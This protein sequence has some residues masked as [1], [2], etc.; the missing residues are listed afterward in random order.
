MVT[1]TSQAAKKPLRMSAKFIIYLLLFFLLTLS[2][3]GISEVLLA[4]DW[5]FLWFILIAGLLSGYFLGILRLSAWRSLLILL[6][7]GLIVPLLF[8]TDL[9]GKILP[10][11][12][13]FYMYSN[14]TQTPLLNFQIDYVSQSEL[15]PQT[16]TS[17]WTVTYRIASWIRGFVI[18]QP[19]IDPV[20]VMVAWCMVIWSVS[21]WAGW[22]ICRSLNSLLAISPLLLLYLGTLSYTR[23]SPVSVSLILG[24][25]LILIAVVQYFK[26]EQHWN[27]SGIPYPERKYRQIMSFA[28]YST[29]GI[30]FFSAFISSLSLQRI[31]SWSIFRREPTYQADTSLAASLGIQPA[32][33]TIP[34]SFSTY[35]D[36]GLPRD[37]LIGSGPELQHIQVMSVEVAE[38]QSIAKIIQ[39][40]SFYW[41]GYTYDTYTGYGWSSST[42]YS[43]TFEAGHIFQ[44]GDS[45]GHILVRQEVRLYPG[46]DRTIYAFGEP[47]TVNVPGIMAW[48]TPQDLFGIQTEGKGAYEITSL[49]P[50]AGESILNAA[51]SIYPDWI[52]N[53]YLALPSDI[54]SRVKELAIHLTATAPTPYDRVRAIEK[55][56]R[57]YEYT[58]EV[59][60]PSISQ[61][62]VDDFLFISKK[63]YCDYYAS[64]MV[65]LARAAGIPA[66][67]V[68]GYASGTYDIKLRRFIITQA[69]AHSW[70][71]VY[72]PGIGWMPFEPTSARPS[73]LSL[74]LTIPESSSPS[75]HPEER[76]VIQ[77]GNTQFTSGIIGLAGTGFILL[78]F[79][80]WIVYDG[81]KLRRLPPQSTA[82][83]IYRRLRRYGTLLK[84]PCGIR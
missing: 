3:A 37:H 48:R 42:L 62:L 45:P 64:A 15:I 4:N 56:L 22:V 55:Y 60:R 44:P 41:R 75:A 24:T 1:I 69:D 65:V 16:I 5:A 25:T 32:T 39:P 9:K 36:P 46:E 21:A 52:Q 26:Q 30:V 79:I 70:A 10:V 8:T 72:F 13:S 18:G 29:I 73:I 19:V 14:H 82:I 35:I 66:R 77:K 78:I 61:D 54:P 47:V 7:V 51:G 84:Y 33:K 12:S 59:D 6:T 76:L 71:E 38:L 57:T 27:S 11:F 17:L 43:D 20:A 58:L 68:T 67:F 81:A 83:E 49:F 50:V 23:I 34:D 53:H 63:G 28:I 74:E 40:S 2:T 31:L 80:A